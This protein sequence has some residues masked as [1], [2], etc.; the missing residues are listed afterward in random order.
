MEWLLYMRE[1]SSH[2]VL[3]DKLL[4]IGVDHMR[5]VSLYNNTVYSIRLIIAMD[6]MSL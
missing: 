6:G 2:I 1:L 5:Q 3:G 4:V